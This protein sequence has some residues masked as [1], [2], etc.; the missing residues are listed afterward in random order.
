MNIR[1][2]GFIHRKML[3][4]KKLL[5]LIISILS[6][7]IWFA[8]P[9]TWDDDT[10]KIYT[11]DKENVVNDYW[12][13][14]PLRDGTTSSAWWIQWVAVIDISSE[15][16]IKQWFMDYIAM[17]INYILWLLALIVIVLIIKDGIVMIWSAWNEEKKKEAFKNLKN[18]IIALILIWAWYLIVNLVFS[19][20]NDSTKNIWYKHNLIHNVI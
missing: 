16:N 3:I 6:L 5:I 12:L 19:F 15:D 17:W 4:F 10:K 20:V 14:D 11:Q 9:Y 13:D 18:Y 2:Y 8:N 7:N 1:F